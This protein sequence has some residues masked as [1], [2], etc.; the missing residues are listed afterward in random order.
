MTADDP[1]FIIA[2]DEHE[3]WNV[4][5]LLDELSGLRWMLGDDWNNGDS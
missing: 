2:A 4:A 5:Y 1:S 3:G